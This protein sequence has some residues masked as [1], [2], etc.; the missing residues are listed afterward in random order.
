MTTAVCDWC[1]KARPLTADGV[2]AKHP[3]SWPVTRSAIH[4]VPDRRATVKRP[5][6]GS[7]KPPR[8]PLGAGR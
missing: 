1:G 4:D 8:R 7:G 3:V 2:L 5:C 6:S